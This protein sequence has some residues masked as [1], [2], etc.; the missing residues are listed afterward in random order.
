MATKTTIILSELSST[1][2]GG[3]GGT[4]DDA[5]DLTG[6]LETSETVDTVTIVSPDDTVLTVSNTQKNSV[7]IDKE[8]GGTIAIA[9][10]VQFQL[11]TQA[12][13]TK[14]TLNLD[15]FVEG[16]SG[17]ADTFGAEYCPIRPSRTSTAGLSAW[18]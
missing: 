11:A 2:T 12:T 3:V 18:A 13:V 1:E 15:M 8:D 10:G 17:S 14:R 9:K 4:R 6:W 5:I 7:P 16:N